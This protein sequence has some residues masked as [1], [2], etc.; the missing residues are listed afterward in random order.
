MN[1]FIAESKN[2]TMDY[3][4]DQNVPCYLYGDDVRI[5]Q[6]I[7]NVVGNAIKYTPKG[8]VTVQAK[9]H[10]PADG[11]AGA[12]V[13]VVTDTGVGIKEQDRDK[14]FGVFQQLDVQTNRNVSGTGLGLAITKQLLTMMGGSIEV[15]SKY[16]AGSTFTINIPVEQGDP[17]KAR[18]EQEISRFVRVKKDASVNVL[19]VDDTR[20]NLNVAQGFLF[21][22]NITPDTVES[23]EDA[24]EAVRRKRYDLVFMDHMMPGMDG[25]EAT[26]RIRELETGDAADGSP[27]QIPIVALSANAVTGA[28]E[29]FLAAGMKDFIPKPIEGRDL[30]AVLAKYLPPDKIETVQQHQAAV[31]G[32]QAEPGAAFPPVDGVDFG[33]GMNRF[34]DAKV[35]LNIIKSYAESTGPLI[36]K[37]AGFGASPVFGGIGLKDYAVL[38]HGIKS[39]SRAIGAVRVG[40]EAE[41]LERAAKS[42]DIAFISGHN[43]AFAAEL[44]RLVDA[45]AALVRSKNGEAQ[46]ANR[47]RPDPALLLR[48]KAAAE[49]Y[50]Y[51]V[52][53]QTM[54]ELCKY[55]YTAA[56]END[57]IKRLTGWIANL[58]YDEVARAIA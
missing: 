38:V 8:S 15:E 49:K 46:K 19:V 24:I 17:A 16:G 57:F 54:E 3:R 25:L 37:I 30:N 11:G 32:A 36:E 35:Y 42:G 7:T 56:G 34:G 48:L 33:A 45:L 23:G 10:G 31:P 14:L 13:V 29:A 58:D 40:E 28:A 52:M 18:N 2:I 50:D 6:I 20:V 26:R 9:Y 1:K 47:E 5:R 27:G 41:R 12:L 51:A 4:M 55:D 21:Q 44:E 22:H 39:S 43:E 53:D